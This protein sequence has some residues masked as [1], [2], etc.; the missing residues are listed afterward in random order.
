MIANLVPLNTRDCSFCLTP[1]RQLEEQKIGVT[2][3]KGH[4]IC[5]SCLKIAAEGRRLPGITF[6]ALGCGSCG[7]ALAAG[8]RQFVGGRIDQG[9]GLCGICIDKF[10]DFRKT[11]DDLQERTEAAR[12]LGVEEHELPEAQTGETLTL[13]ELKARVGDKD[14]A[15]GKK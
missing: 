10:A 7:I 4:G 5:Y 1:A 12:G 3:F 8:E 11:V 6:E 9:A 15:E 13:D 14:P 2:N